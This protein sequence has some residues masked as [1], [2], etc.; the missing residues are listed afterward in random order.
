ML[1]TNTYKPE[2]YTSA[3]PYLI[4]RDAGGTIAFL[5]RVFDADELRRFDGPDRRVM[6]AEV[7]IDDTVVMMGEAA[8]GWP[9]QPAHVHVYVPDV[10]AAYR[11]AMDAGAESVQEPEQKGDPD[12]RG[13]VKDAYGTTWWIATTIGES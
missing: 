9:A 10:A 7:R 6:H 1:M 2:G 3:A 13:G 5:K 4:V 11:R 12:K 8:D